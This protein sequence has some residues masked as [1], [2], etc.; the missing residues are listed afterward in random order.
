MSGDA[1][2]LY[3][4]P[5]QYRVV[6]YRDAANNDYEFEQFLTVASDSSQWVIKVPVD[7]MKVQVPN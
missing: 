7:A 6:Y 1:F 4:G 3:A 5:G 2:K